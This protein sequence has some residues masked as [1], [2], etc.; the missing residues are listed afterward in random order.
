MNIFRKQKTTLNSGKESE[1]KIECDALTDEDLDCI[2]YLISNKVNFRKVISVPSGGDRLA[3]KLNKYC[4]D[5]DSLPAL[6]CDDVLTTGG[7]MNR[8]KEEI[9]EENVIGIVI[10]ARDEC[11]DWIEP[12]FIMNI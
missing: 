10:F 9:D 2:A 8:K 1:F 12:L 7:S 3:E 4:Q 5:D 11:P 6:I